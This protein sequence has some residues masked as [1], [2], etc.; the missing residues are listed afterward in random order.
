MQKAPFYKQETEHSCGVASLKMV[1]GY[2]DLNFSERKLAT[3]LETVYKDEVGIDRKNLAKVARLCGCVAVERV[4]QNFKDIEKYL[5]LGFPVIVNYI[6]Y[7]EFGHFA[8]VVGIEKDVLILNDP[9]NS[10]RDRISFKDFEKVW[11][12][13]DGKYSNRWL[14]A[15]K[16]RRD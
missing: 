16:K 14:M 8:V 1:L 11:Q 6:W 9:Y 10:K 5:G 7:D 2:V 15:I 3:L 12:S 13:F 4:N